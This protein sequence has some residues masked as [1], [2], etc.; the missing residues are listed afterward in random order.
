MN[1]KRKLLSTV[2]ATALLAACG[3]GGLSG[4]YNGGMGSIT[5]SGSHADVK[6]M[7]NTREIP[8][9]VDG[10]KVVLHAASAGNLVLTRNPD[11]SLTTPWGI[12]RIFGGTYKAADGSMTATFSGGEASFNV[13]AG[14]ESFH[15]KYDI[16]GSRVTVHTPKGDMAMELDPDGALV[17]PAG[18][19]I[20]QH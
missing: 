13:A 15:A 3:G 8:Y 5:F 4:T 19:L 17:T 18:K 20:P 11:G 1:G 16:D 7:G 6:V 14:N 10:N 2:F 9:S 12:M